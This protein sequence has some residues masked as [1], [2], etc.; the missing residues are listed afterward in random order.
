MDFLPALKSG[1]SVS[2]LCI[3]LSH[4]PVLF[5]TVVGLMPGLLQTHK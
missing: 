1:L 5:V 4:R 2:E 3:H